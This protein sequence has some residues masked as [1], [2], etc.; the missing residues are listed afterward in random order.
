[1]DRVDIGAEWNQEVNDSS[2]AGNYTSVMA[3]IIE[4]AL[5]LAIVGIITC[6][7]VGTN[8]FASTPFLVIWGTLAVSRISNKLFASLINAILIGHFSAAYHCP[9]Y[10]GHGLVT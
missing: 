2:N 1:M 6:V 8:N 9:Y 5:P 10:D 3:I 4:S 7:L